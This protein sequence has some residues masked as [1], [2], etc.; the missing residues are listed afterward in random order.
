MLQTLIGVSF[1]L[2]MVLMLRKPARH[3]FG[4]GPAFTLWLLPPLLALLPWLPLMPLRFSL[5]PSAPVVVS[6]THFMAQS[7]TAVST[8]HWPLWLWLCGALVALLRL[9]VRYLRQRARTRALPESIWTAVRR[10]LHPFSASRVRLHPDGPAALWAPRSLL[11]LPPDFLDHFDPAERRLVLRHELTHLRRLD[12]LWSLF[13]EL[14]CALLW[15]HPLAWLALPR[16]RLDQELACDERVLREA[17]KDEIRYAQTLMQSAGIA[18]TPVLIP[19]LAEPQLKERLQMINRRC[20]GALRRCIGVMAIVLLMTG[21]AVAAQS[22][23]HGNADETKA[24]MNVI[25]HSSPVY[26]ADAIKQKHQG[27]VVLNVLVGTDGKPLSYKVDPSTKAAPELVTAASKAAMQWQFNPKMENGKP[28]E[29]YARVPVT[30][31]LDETDSDKSAARPRS[32][33]SNEPAFMPGPLPSPP[34]PPPPAAPTPP[35]PPP[36]PPT[37]SSSSF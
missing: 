3:C 5:V 32:A 4:A 2:G 11:L 21:T 13:A 33:R 37:P 23:V 29:G 26:P 9:A 17:P 24:S 22:A 10:E 20:P 30:F 14:G 19:W 8:I 18:M 36:P 28:V 27:T 15:F 12:P 31:S 34:P 35:P 1:G 7:A 6:A 25:P 16:L